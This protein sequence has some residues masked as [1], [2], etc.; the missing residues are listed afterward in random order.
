[1]IA[2][3]FYVNYIMTGMQ[4]KLWS[5]SDNQQPSVVISITDLM[6]AVILIM[7]L[8]VNEVLH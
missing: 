3:G 2:N 1:M 4:L 8:K 6:R 5:N 7:F